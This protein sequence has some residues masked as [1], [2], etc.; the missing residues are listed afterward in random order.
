MHRMADVLNIN[1]SDLVIAAGLART[2]ADADRVAS[3]EIGGKIS[4]RHQGSAH[5]APSRLP[6]EQRTSE[7]IQLLR[8]INLARDNRIAILESMLSVWRQTDLAESD[9]A[10]L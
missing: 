7:A 1:I 5:L 10:E 4:G 3:V 8:K 2:K 9:Q 6:L